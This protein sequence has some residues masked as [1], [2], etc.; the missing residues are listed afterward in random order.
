MKYLLVFFLSLIPLTSFGES[1]TEVMLNLGVI[2][3]GGSDGE[4]PLDGDLDSW[5]IVGKHHFN[6]HLMVELGYQSRN[7][8]YTLTDGQDTD[9]D[10]DELKLK[11]GYQFVLG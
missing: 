6:N 3:G 10:A 2:N 5:E 4:F 8:E 7:G 1:K 11:I 9:Y